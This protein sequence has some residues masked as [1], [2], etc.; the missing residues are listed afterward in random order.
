V[1]G[2]ITAVGREATQL[3]M[4]DTGWSRSTRLSSGVVSN[5]E[6]A[7]ELLRHLLER[8]AWHGLLKPRAL[9]CIPSDA[10]EEE[11]NH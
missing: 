11:R 10:C 7:T 1:D 2:E 8:V 4:S 9:A 3:A 6:A 5:I